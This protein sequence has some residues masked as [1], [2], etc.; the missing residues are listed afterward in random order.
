MVHKTNREAW[1][2]VKRRMLIALLVAVIS[3][4]ATFIYLV[5]STESEDVVVAVVDIPA[6]SLIGPR[7]V[8]IASLNRGAVHP[9]AYRGIEDVAGRYTSQ[10]V[11]AGEQV[12]K[13]RVAAG[14]HGGVVSGLAGDLRAMFIP[15][16]DSRAVGGRLKRGGRVDVVFVSSGQH[17]PSVAK[18]VLTSVPIIQCGVAGDTAGSRERDGGAP[19]TVVAVTPR[20]AEKLAFCLENGKVYLTAVPY[21]SEPSA[22]PGVTW[23]DVCFPDALTQP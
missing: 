6:N 22:S 9:G 8:R 5:R 17:N 13:H 12:L 3:S 21:G 18:C 23:K 1:L 11:V 4:T 10:A 19:G 7:S 2:L 15:I 16:D 20:D 14:E